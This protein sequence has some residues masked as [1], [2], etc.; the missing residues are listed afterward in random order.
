MSCSKECAGA[1]EERIS[2]E[3][4][5]ESHLELEHTVGMKKEMLA[6]LPPCTLQGSTLTRLRFMVSMSED[7]ACFASCY[8]YGAEH[9]NSKAECPS[10]ALSP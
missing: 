2:K 9:K 10:G 7:I 8:I 5:L 1:S 6:Y 4:E 3:T